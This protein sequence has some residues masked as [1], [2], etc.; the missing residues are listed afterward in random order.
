MPFQSTCEPDIAASTYASCAT[1]LLS[2][3]HCTL[4]NY[5]VSVIIPVRNDA[6]SLARCLRALAS[7]ETAHI[8]EVIVVDNASRDRAAVC[9]AALAFAFVTVVHEP[10]IGTAAA[11]NAGLVA[12]T[13]DIIAFLDA[14]CLCGPHWLEQGVATLL[15][16]PERAVVGGR[17][18]WADGPASFS[19]DLDA[20]L[21]FQQERYLQDERFLL[22]G[23]VFFRR[24]VL[25]RAGPF[26]SEQRASEDEEWCRRAARAGCLLTYDASLV[27]LHPKASDMGRIWSRMRRNALGK[28]DLYLTEHASNPRAFLS[29]GLT[30]FRG[31][32]GCCRR[33]L[34]VLD[35][36]PFRK[37]AL[38]CAWIAVHAYA[39]A[40]MAWEYPKSVRRRSRSLAA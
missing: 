8:F 11:R 33:R 30:S 17:V 5:L 10:R 38:L 34:D 40:V 19:A 20:V 29:R 7:Q 23:N 31:Y 28:V 21:Y 36:S 25:E 3:V 35:A 2:T 13:G 6:G 22:T 18:A 4:K 9:E 24:C 26:A 1:V 16:L 39:F 14:D 27:V 12:A 32:A 15:S 37:A